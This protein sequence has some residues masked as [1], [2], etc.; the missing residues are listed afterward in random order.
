[1]T[2]RVTTDAVVVDASA[3]VAIA[4]GEPAGETV[5][6]R[7]EGAAVFAP[8]LLKFEMANAAWKRA[9]RRP[10]EATEI[11]NALSVMLDHRWSIAW[12]DVDVADA[13]L[14]AHAINMTAYDASYLWLAGSLGADLITLDERLA[15]LS[16]ALGA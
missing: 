3:L 14:I 6:R 4:F 1:M 7:L 16:E 11:F 9:R 13:V 10:R 15:R 5:A 8:Y 12:Q 2:T